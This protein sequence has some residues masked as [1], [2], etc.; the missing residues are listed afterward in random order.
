MT[1]NKSRASRYLL[2]LAVAALACNAGDKAPK[3]PLAQQA[4]ADSVHK[5]AGVAQAGGAVALGPEAQKALDSGNVLFRKKAYAPALAQYRLASAH[6]PNHAAPYIGMN[7]V[8]QA[9]GDKALADSAIAAIRERGGAPSM[10]QHPSIDS[11]AKKA[12]ANV[13]KGPIS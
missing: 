6:A 11:A 10:G 2:L 1:G 13:K 4:P 7:M 8:A 12:S 5:A 3:V 9:T